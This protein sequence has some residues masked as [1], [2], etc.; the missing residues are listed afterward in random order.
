MLNLLQQ[1]SAI[2][3]HI[4]HSFDF[5]MTVNVCTQIRLPH[6]ARSDENGSTF[7]SAHVTQVVDA[8]RRGELQHPYTETIDCE[9][10]REDGC[11]I[12]TKDEMMDQIKSA[13]LRPPRTFDQST[14][15]ADDE[16]TTETKLRV[17]CPHRILHNFK[18]TARKFLAWTYNHVMLC[19]ACICTHTGHQIILVDGSHRQI[20]AAKAW[21]VLVPRAP[22]GRTACPTPPIQPM[23]TGSID[24]TRWSATTINVPTSP[25]TGSDQERR[26]SS[27]RGR[28]ASRCPRQRSIHYCVNG[29]FC[30]YLSDCRRN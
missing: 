16:T 14:Q 27:A 11:Q 7:D 29:A 19:S 22:H 26:C 2:F 24:A 12:F 5:G 17:S 8:V 18:I 23:S 21:C 3:P 1:W 30:P 13:Q 15:L 25:E 9:A 10:I 28:C 6:R 20:C 4:C